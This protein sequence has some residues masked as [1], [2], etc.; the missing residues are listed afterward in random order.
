MAIVHVNKNSVKRSTGVGFREYTGIMANILILGI[1]QFAGSNF[2]ILVFLFLVSALFK[3]NS[4]S[5][6]LDIPQYHFTQPHRK[7]ADN[8]V[9]WEHYNGMS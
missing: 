1:P 2:F 3:N 6:C 8:P 5:C 4:T 9:L 7:T